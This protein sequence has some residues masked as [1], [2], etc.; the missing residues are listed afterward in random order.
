M[1]EK[2]RARFLTMLFL[3]EEKFCAPLQVC[4]L[5]KQWRFF[6]IPPLSVSLSK[7]AAPWHDMQGGCQ[8]VWGKGGVETLFSFVIIVTSITAAG[9]N[10]HVKGES[11]AMFGL[12]PP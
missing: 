3:L 1:D 8:T 4:E 11:A 2:M 10:G 6:S 9:I 12:V 7:S 5:F